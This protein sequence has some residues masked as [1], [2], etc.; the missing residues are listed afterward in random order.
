[1]TAQLRNPL[2]SPFLRRA[3]EL[4]QAGFLCDAVIMVGSQVFRAHSL[5]LACASRE[6]E[7]QLTAAEDAHRRHCTVDA[8]SARTFQQVM[9]YVYA[10][11]LEVS[12]EDLRSLLRA[13]RL[14]EMEELGEQC[15]VWLRMLDS[16]RRVRGSGR[17]QGRHRIWPSKLGWGALAS[18][19]SVPP[20]AEFAIRS[21]HSLQSSQ[22]LLAYSI[23]YST[24]IYSLFPP[25]ALPQMHDSLMSYTRLLHPFHHSL[26]QGP[27]KMAV[28]LKHSLLGKKASVD[29]ELIVG[30]E[31]EGGV[32]KFQGSADRLFHCLQCRKEFLDNRKLQMHEVTSSVPLEPLCCPFCGKNQVS[33]SG[34][35]PTHTRRWSHLCPDCGRSFTSNTAVRRHRRLHTGE[36]SLGCEYCDRCFRDESSLQS[37]RRIHSGEKPYQCQR[38]PKRFSLKHQ[39]NTHYRVHTGEKP[40]ECRLCGQRSRDYSA[41]I[42]HLRTHG[43]AAPYQCTICLEYCNS[44]AAMQKHLK[45]HP[46]QD[47]PPNWSIS[48]T[49]LYTSHS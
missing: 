7:R 38:C 9:N 1:M 26:L 33:R 18:R 39:L 27:Q 34:H 40:F 44:L 17:R 16:D 3:G 4:R 30:N 35:L 21:L 8:L 5:V 2:Y 42:K 48:S 28:S 25:P 46:V 6:L 36:L 41:M 24:P 32:R 31:P 12:V 10:D 22:P 13:A 14:L 45:A 11:T 29:A 15:L 19:G 47:F 37:H 20:D 43:G 49:Y 23:P